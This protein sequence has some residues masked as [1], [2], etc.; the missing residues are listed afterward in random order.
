M[1]QQWNTTPY[2]GLPKTR[3]AETPGG[4]RWIAITDVVKQWYNRTWR[5]FFRE[6]SRV[7]KNVQ[8]WG[9]CKG[10]GSEPVTN[11][12]KSTVRKAFIW[13]TG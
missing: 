11:I 2:T 1:P 6:G 3:E 7:V 8:T 4:Y 10:N 9:F 13:G 5:P 12:I